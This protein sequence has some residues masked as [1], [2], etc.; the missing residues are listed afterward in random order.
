MLTRQLYASKRYTDKD[1]TVAVGTCAST[2]QCFK[3]VVC[4]LPSEVLTQEFALMPVQFK[5]VA[6]GSTNY[7]CLILRSRLAA[8]V[9]AH[10]ARRNAFPG[11][12]PQANRTSGGRCPGGIR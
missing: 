12:Q 8:A 11:N 9:D 6:N 4:K 5:V 10:P 2:K 3:N 7:M 1:P